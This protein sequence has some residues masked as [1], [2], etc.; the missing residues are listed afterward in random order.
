MGSVAINTLWQKIQHATPFG[1]RVLL[2]G[3]TNVFLALFG[4]ISG[5]LAARLLGPQ[6]RGELA[7]I[8]VWPSA[9]ATFAMLGLPEALV[10]YSAREPDR[11]GRYLGSA[12][13]LALLSSVPS[14]ALG[15][16]LMPLLLSAQSAEIIMAARWY[17][18]LVPIFALV[19]MQY[20]P[21]QG[22]GDFTVWNALRIMLAMGW[23]AVLVMAW[24]LERAEPQFV[25]ASYLVT[26]ALLFFPLMYV[27]AR[28]VPGPFLP[29]VQ[30]WRP[31]L[32]YG[33]PSMA[34]SV[35]Q[36][37]NFRLDQM[38]MAAF[39]PAQ[40][41]GLYVVAV[42]WSGAVNPLLNA[43]GAVVFPNVASEDGHE[44]QAH[45]FAQGSR[46]GVLASIV[47]AFVLIILTPWMV[48]LL[49]GKNFASAIPAALVLVVAGAI[50]GLNLVMEE[51]LRGLG[52]PVSVMWAEFGGLA[53]T[54]ISLLVLLRPLEI[55]GAAL[56]SLL[57]YSAVAFFLIVQARRLTGH[58]PVALL[59]P[60][61]VEIRSFWNRLKSVEVMG[62]MK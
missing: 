18:L 53:V 58:S 23:L 35:P 51:G 56:A 34:S 2:T 47:M 55:I 10:Y 15:Y 33:L 40:A 54:A 45:A 31:M 44:R 62:I 25:A 28:R 16:L 48:P 26:L 38:L 14:V 11:A 8:Q 1:S 3:A 12:V 17:L 39:L 60:S 46:L 30:R 52:H 5:V 41:L 36:M 19:G 6:G 61:V 9:I 32:R 20:H 37:M 13:M 7:A 42:A 29:D 57:G 21:L 22:R 24:L 59:C 43:L 49:F 27:V 50:A 4:L